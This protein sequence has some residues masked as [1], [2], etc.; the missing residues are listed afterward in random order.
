MKSLIHIIKIVVF[1]IELRL[2]RVYLPKI[3]K[4]LFLWN[5]LTSL[6]HIIKIVVFGIELDELIFEIKILFIGMDL[7]LFHVYFPNKSKVSF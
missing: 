3:R 1:G 6:I 5:L 2:F 7:R 4:F